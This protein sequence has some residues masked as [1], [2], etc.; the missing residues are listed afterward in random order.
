MTW[1]ALR[2]TPFLLV[3][4]TISSALPAQPIFPPPDGTTILSK[5]ITYGGNSCPQGS[6]GHVILNG[7]V[8]NSVQLAVTLDDFRMFSSISSGNGLRKECN[9]AVNL[10]IPT[11]Y[12]IQVASDSTESFQSFDNKDITYRFKDTIYYNTGVEQVS[13]SFILHS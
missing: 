4:R 10:V 1:I 8:Q 7:N 11:G 12:K 13:M 6:V 9:I 2:F 3:F 5:G